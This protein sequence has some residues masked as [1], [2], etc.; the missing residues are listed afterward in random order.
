V[1]KP[2]LLIAGYSYYPSSGTGDW[3]GCCETEEAAQK[4]WE[5]IKEEESDEYGLN[6]HN[7]VDLRKWTGDN[8]E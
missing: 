6:W 5:N 3:V 8:E 7:V 4:I 2:F 1:K